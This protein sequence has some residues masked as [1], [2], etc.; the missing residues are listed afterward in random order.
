MD[1]PKRT[2]ASDGEEQDMQ[3]LHA[4][5]LPSDISDKWEAAPDTDVGSNGGEPNGG[6]APADTA[7]EVAEG[8]LRNIWLR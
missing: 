1:I 7:P 8:R 6:H 4:V 5:Y 3:F 2:V